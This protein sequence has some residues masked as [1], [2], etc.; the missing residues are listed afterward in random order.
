MMGED[1]RPAPILLIS[2]HGPKPSET[3]EE[4]REKSRPFGATEKQ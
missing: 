2:R 3:L 4:S 1:S